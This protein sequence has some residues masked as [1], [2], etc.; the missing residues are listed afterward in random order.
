[1]ML[2]LSAGKNDR[3][4]NQATSLPQ[5]V[6]QKRNISYGP[7]R[8]SSLLD[9]YYPEGT[10][11][12]LP[13]I[14]SVH[15]GGYVYGNKEIYRYYCMD[16]ARRGFTV[17][18]FNYRLAPRRR[19]PAPLEDTNRVLE[20]LCRCDYPVDPQ[21]VFLVG[22][23]AGAQIVSQY[24]AIA[25]NADYAALFS[26][27]VP[28][29]RIRAIGLNCGMYDTAALSSGKR[30]GIIRD[31]LGT[32]ISSQDPR[33]AVLEHIT[34]HYPPAHITTACNDFLKDNAAPM[35]QL[36]SQRSVP[37]RTDCYGTP[38]RQDIG[39]VF[40]VDIRLEEATLCNDQQCNFFLSHL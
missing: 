33:I 37:V 30:S 19:F 15:G 21:R 29:V 4:R 31:Y 40:H 18:N 24:A 20:W 36:L 25:T 23:S 34:S 3:L 22:D 8:K 6:C 14:V 2:R 38:E 1:M 17:V 39:H 26:F 7:F 35:A 32:K 11:T 16:L 10:T 13:T 12:P 9:V 5:G 27:A 28:P